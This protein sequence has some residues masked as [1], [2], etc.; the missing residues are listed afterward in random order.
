MLGQA[1]VAERLVGP[2]GTVVQSG[3]DGSDGPIELNAMTR[4]HAC[5]SADTL[6]VEVPVAFAPTLNACAQGPFRV[7]D[8]SMRNPSSSGELSFHL[9]TILPAS[10]TASVSEGATTGGGR[11]VAHAALEKAE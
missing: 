5:C 6:Y 2:A 7:A 1:T 11:V 10:G 4:K 8:R 3:I 9:M